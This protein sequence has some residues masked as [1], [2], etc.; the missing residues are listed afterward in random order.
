MSVDS[1]Y[2]TVIV[3]ELT[4]SSTVSGSCTV[5]QF[6]DDFSSLHPDHQIT[7]LRNDQGQTLEPQN[8]FSS[9]TN[10]D[11]ITLYGINQVD[12]PT[13]ANLPSR[14]VVHQGGASGCHR[15]FQG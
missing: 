10:S 8:T 5:R 11:E 6:I 12:N 9:I 4:F 15:L 7:G 3:D 1:I 14:P 13:P 2:V